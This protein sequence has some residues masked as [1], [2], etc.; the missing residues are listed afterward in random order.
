MEPACHLNGILSPPPYSSVGALPWPRPPPPFTGGFS[1][2]VQGPLSL[3]RTLIMSP[4]GCLECGAIVRP[5]AIKPPPGQTG[6]SLFL[7][8]A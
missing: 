4:Y 3:D 6:A 1:G 7:Y 8:E 2:N 5:G